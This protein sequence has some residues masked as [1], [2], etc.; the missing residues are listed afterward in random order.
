MSAAHQAPRHIRA[1]ASEPYHS[2]LHCFAPKLVD[3]ASITPYRRHLAGCRDAIS[4]S[5]PIPRRLQSLLPA[6]AELRAPAL[7]SLRNCLKMLGSTVL[8]D[9]LETMNGV[10]GISM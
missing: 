3:G 5:H 9:S 6:A 8:P 7:R 10:F 1:H 2:E 4:A